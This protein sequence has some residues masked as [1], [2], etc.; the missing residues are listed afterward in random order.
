VVVEEEV[1]VAEVAPPSQH[2]LKKMLQLKI[3]LEI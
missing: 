3:L 2:L 1:E